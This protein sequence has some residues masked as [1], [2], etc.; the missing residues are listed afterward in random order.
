[1]KETTGPKRLIAANSRKRSQ[2]VASNLFPSCPFPARQLFDALGNSPIGIAICNR[3]FRFAAVNRK[4]AEINNIPQ[5]EHPGRIIH[6]LVGNIA[7]TVEARLEHVF[8]KGQPLYNAQL[9]GRLGANPSPGHWLEHYFP[10]LDDFDRVRHVGV[11]VIPLLGL[12]LHSDPNRSLAGLSLPAGS[13]TPQPA[14]NSEKLNHPNACHISEEDQCIGKA[15]TA[16]ETDVLRLLADG[17]SS[18]EA[19]VTLEIS[20]KTVETY[21][22]RLMLK[23][24]ATSF[25]DLVHYA[26]RHQVVDL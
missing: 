13:Q 8:S 11:F 10:I 14:S 21:R 26:I 15:L 16:R 2:R 19:S 20:L 24:N 12:R 4:L 9:I 23:I 18:K 25:A 22:A 7:L 17:S 3:H 1:M 6:E 5:E